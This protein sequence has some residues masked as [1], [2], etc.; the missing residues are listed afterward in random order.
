[1]EAEEGRWVWRVPVGCPRSRASA[2][3]AD[4]SSPSTATTTRCSRRFATRPG[5]SSSPTAPPTARYTLLR[6]S[7][8]PPPP[9]L[10]EEQ[11]QGSHLRLRRRR[12][13]L[14][15]RPQYYAL[16]H[17]SLSV[18]FGRLILIYRQ[19]RP[20]DASSFLQV[21]PAALSLRLP[22]TYGIARNSLV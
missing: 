6:S 5:G 15:H 18:S 1:V 12:H 14:H 3:T 21:S 16:S 17:L 22:G 2:C 13:H 8:P 20:I 19:Y 11:G 4:T 10:A 7:P 9:C